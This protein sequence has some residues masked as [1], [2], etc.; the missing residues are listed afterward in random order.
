MMMDIDAVSIYRF[1]TSIREVE[2]DLCQEVSREE[3]I[4]IR[5]LVSKA[6]KSSKITG[7]S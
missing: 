4:L 1:R 2:D 6:G 5:K 3:I 7:R